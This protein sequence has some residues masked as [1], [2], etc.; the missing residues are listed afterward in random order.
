[1]PCIRGNGINIY[2][3]EQ[4]AGEPIVCMA[5]MAAS[6]DS[7]TPARAELA[8]HF[9]VV[10]FDNRGIGQT[11]A[12]DAPYS[13]DQMADDTAALIDAL[14][15]HSAHIAGQS[16][17][18]G[19][20][21]SLAVRHPQRVRKLILC[22]PFT[23][24]SETA[25]F[26][27]RTNAHLLREGAPASLAF[28]VILPWLF[29]DAFFQDQTKVRA[30]IELTRA[31]P[32]QQTLQA[33]ERQIDALAAFDSEKMLKNISAPT[34]IIA[35]AHDLMTPADAA[36]AMAQRIPHA[37]FET[38]AAGHLSIVESPAVVSKLIADFLRD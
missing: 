21:Q 5:G 36:R 28:E 22:N 17:G 20:A 25:L 31:L 30:T 2:Y 27:F 32:P 12:P 14:A 15:L 26:V 7:W 1:M 11:D 10:T 3:E 35:G 9:R 23:R 6:H 24:I 19:I 16:M 4:G 13:I 38:V 33:F 37:R 34:L 8:R 29:S 18:S